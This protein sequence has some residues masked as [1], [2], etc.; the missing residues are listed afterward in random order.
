M[1]ISDEL[2]TAIINCSASDDG[3]LKIKLSQSTFDEC[4]LWINNMLSNSDIESYQL[5]INELKNIKPYNVPVSFDSKN[6]IYAIL[7]FE[8]ILYNDDTI[9]FSFTNIVPD[10]TGQIMNITTYIMSKISLTPGTVLKKN[11]ILSNV[12][13]KVKKKNA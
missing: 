12:K 13:Y 11:E 9:P 10:I 7:S 1:D 2:R 3:Q 5:D 6:D 8:Y 4:H